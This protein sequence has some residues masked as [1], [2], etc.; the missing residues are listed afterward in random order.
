MNH[1]HRK[2]LE[3]QA[4]MEDMTAPGRCARCSHVHDKAAVTVLGTYSDC[5]V[6]ACPSCG[7]MIDDRPVGWGGSFLPITA[8]PALDVFA[9]TLTEIRAL[10]CSETW[11]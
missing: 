6:W 11:A 2:R 10:P 1:P 4:A 7:A 5:S 9:G 3:A 8:R